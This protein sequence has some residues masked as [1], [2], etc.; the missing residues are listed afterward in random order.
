MYTFTPIDHINASLQSSIC[1]LGAS[2]VHGTALEYIATNTAVVFAAVTI[3]AVTTSVTGTGTVF[4]PLTADATTTML[5]KIP[6]FRFA[7]ALKLSFDP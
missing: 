4:V 1:I 5:K 3:A 2:T 6:K 7:A